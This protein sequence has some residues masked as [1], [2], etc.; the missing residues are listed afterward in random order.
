MFV[1]VALVHLWHAALVGG[2]HRLWHSGHIL[3]SLGMIIMFLPVPTMLL[4]PAAGTVLFALAALALAG[5]VLLSRLRG[6][7]IGALWAASVI[8]LVWMAVMFIEMC[9]G[10]DTGVANRILDWVNILGLLWFAVQALGWASGLLGR[11]LD[12]HGLGAATT[13]A[14]PDE[15]HHGIVDGGTH[16]W[17]VRISL[18]IM[19]VGM[20][21]ML[22]SFNHGMLAMESM[23]G[24]QE[25]KSQ[26]PPAQHTPET[27][28]TSPGRSAPTTPVHPAPSAHPRPSM[29][30]M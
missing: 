29:P 28:P 13:P 30:G 7:S 4:D 24:M 17:P 19:A 2:R 20:G 21:Y 3:T 16:D 25:T 9:T 8:D 5:Y 14:Q 1:G 11:V 22:L 23:P 15:R 12:R 27:H 10:W 26:P 6:G 18:A